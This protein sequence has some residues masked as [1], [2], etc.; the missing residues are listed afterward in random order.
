M[1][2]LFW[3]TL[4]V[5]CTVA[6]VSSAACPDRIT[7]YVLKGSQAYDTRTG[8]TWQ[9]CSVGTTW[10]GR[11]GCTGDPA[12]IGLSDALKAAEAAGPGWRVPTVKELHGLLDRRCGS[13]PVDTAAFPDLRA[14]E[15]SKEGNQD[16]ERIYWTASELGIAGLVYYV[17]FA[18]G[19]VDAHT[20]G[21][22]LAVRLVRTGS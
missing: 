21:F 11:A 10:N 20:R 8:L 5:L 12:Q 22:S 14:A 13:P 6:N 4:T 16:G 7:R 19:D 1:M 15:K 3:P 17:D 2:R 18:T 9:R